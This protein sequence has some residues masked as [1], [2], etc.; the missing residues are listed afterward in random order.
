MQRVFLNETEAAIFL[1]IAPKTLSRWRWVGRG[2]NFHKFG[3]A[4]RYSLQ[5]LENFA[6][7]SAVTQ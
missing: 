7:S 3:G 4:V 5:D 2:P 1:H 6:Q